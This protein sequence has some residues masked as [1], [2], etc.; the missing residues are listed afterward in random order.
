MQEWGNGRSSRE[1]KAPRG[2]GRTLKW[3]L[4]AKLVR[5]CSPTSYQ[6]LN[7]GEF[8]ERDKKSTDNLPA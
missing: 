1:M 5:P 6:L 4:P 3:D 2:W 7:T 8:D